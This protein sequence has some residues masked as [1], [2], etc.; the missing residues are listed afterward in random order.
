MPI[1]KRLTQLLD[2]RFNTAR[3]FDLKP[4]TVSVGAGAAALTRK[5]VRLNAPLYDHFVS[6]QDDTLI[7]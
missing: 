1:L 5:A 4:N 6:N 3:W 7:F 2:G